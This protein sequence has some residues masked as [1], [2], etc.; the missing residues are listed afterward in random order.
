[1]SEDKKYSGEFICPNCLKYFDEDFVDRFYDPY[2]KVEYCG[3]CFRKIKAKNY[4]DKLKDL[5]ARGI[6]VNEFNK[7][8]IIGD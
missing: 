6:H 1:M 8:F 2:E 7:R 4:S 3:D 5:I